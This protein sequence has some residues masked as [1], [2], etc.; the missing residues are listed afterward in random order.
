MEIN[1]PTSKSFSFKRTALSHGWYDLPPF[2]LDSQKW[3]LTRVIDLGRSRP[4]VAE[5]S[6]GKQGVTVVINRTVDPRFVDK[7]T[8]DVRHMLRLDDDMDPFYDIVTRDADMSWIAT[9]GAGRLLRAPTVFED[10]VK[11]I[12][13]TNCSWA[14]TDKMINCLVASLGRKA[15]GGRRA[16]PTA[17]SMASMPESFYRDE[18]RSG[19]RAGY[20]KELAERVA[21]GDID[22]ESW[23]TSELPTDELKREIKRVKGV[24]NYAAENV[25]RLVGRYD[26][27][28]LDSWVRGKFAKMHNGARKTSDKKIEQHYS[29][30]GEWRGLALWCDMTRDWFQD[31]PP[32][33]A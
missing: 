14:L 4:V 17:E 6:E 9:A 27:L 22:V 12:C 32:S 1:I 13:T 2:E 29:R 21:G 3:I 30:Y 31:E 33:E 23:L 18:V 15:D 26:G 16:F 19:Y 5:I 28:A 20:L 8:R 25:L 7:I 10:L 11:M 24:G